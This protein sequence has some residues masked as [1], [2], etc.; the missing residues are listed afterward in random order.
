MDRSRITAAV[1]GIEYP[2]DPEGCAGAD[3]V[4]VDL[5]RRADAL[6]AV[7]AQAPTARIIAFGPHVDE[8]VFERGAARRCRPGARPISVLPRHRVRPRVTSRPD[9]ESDSAWR[10]CLPCCR[11]SKPQPTDRARS[12]SSVR[13]GGPTDR[14]TSVSW[15]ELHDDARAMAAALQARGVGPGA[16]VAL[17]GPT[18]RPLVTAIQATWLCGAA[19]VDAA[20]ADAAR[21]DRGVR[22]ADPRAHRARRTRCSSSIDAQLAPVPRRRSPAT[23]RSCH[24]R[25]ARVGAPRRRR[26]RAARPTTPTRSRSCSSRADRPP[27]RRA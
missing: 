7:R 13:R 5:A 2:A 21:L 25:R 14:S 11:V 8:Q 24:A 6:A 18:T 12:R 15:P 27:T 1:P 17:L 9:A 22:R 20:A 26:V 19:T 23:R 10:P 4:I 3:V 16:H